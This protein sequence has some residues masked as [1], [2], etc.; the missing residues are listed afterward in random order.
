MSSY[1]LIKNGNRFGPYTKEEILIKADEHTLLWREG[2]KEWTPL[3]E[4][5]EFKKL[6]EQTPPI[7]PEAE[8]E[9]KQIMPKTWLVEA[10]LV[11]IFCC[12]PFGIVAIIKA[13][14]VDRYYISN[15]YEVSITY[16]DKARR[17]VKVGFF[18]GITWLVIYCL[19]VAVGVSCK[20]F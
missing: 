20:Y 14:L 6:I 17:W 18:M 11:T 5:E 15:L 2:L 10:I 12:L 4:I 13:S 3:R 7:P 19:I 8:A 9:K 1:Y 16:S